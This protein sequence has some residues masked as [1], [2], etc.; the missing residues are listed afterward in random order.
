M[1]CKRRSNKT[2]PG[3]GEEL[4]KRSMKELIENMSIE[5][6]VKT[7]KIDE[8]AILSYERPKGRPKK[9]QKRPSTAPSAAKA[10]KLKQKDILEVQ[11]IEND[12]QI[13]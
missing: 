8:N 10:Y 5:D 4:T 2:A 7:T 12:E 11:D 1:M 13:E 9:K 3:N 6:L